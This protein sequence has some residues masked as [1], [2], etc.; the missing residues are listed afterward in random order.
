[1]WSLPLPPSPPFFLPSI[2]EQFPFLPQFF[3]CGFTLQALSRVHLIPFPSNRIPLFFLS[4]FDCWQWLNFSILIRASV[5]VSLYSLLF[6]F[7]LL[8]CWQTPSRFQLIDKFGFFLIIFFC[9]LLTIRAALP[10][11]YH[12]L[13]L[14]RLFPCLVSSPQS[15]SPSRRFPQDFPPF[16]SLLVFFFLIVLTTSQAD[17][18]YSERPLFN[19][20]FLPWTLSLLG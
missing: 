11:K 8:L 15:L 7:P 3:L 18:R 5:S 16:F 12:P 14:L 2:R 6:P 20:A 13:P 10:E 17:P 1:M 19:C 9:I 4:S